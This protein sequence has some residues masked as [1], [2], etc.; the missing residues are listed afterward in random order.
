MRA[1]FDAVKAGVEG[2]GGEAEMP[3]PNP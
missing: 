2:G 3:L 1:G